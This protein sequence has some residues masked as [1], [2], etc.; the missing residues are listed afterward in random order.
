MNEARKL[1]EQA[2]ELHEQVLES[3]CRILGPDHRDTLFAMEDLARG[4]LRAQ[5]KADE[6]RKLHGE[7]LKIR[8]RILVE[9]PGWSSMVGLVIST[10]SAPD[11][12]NDDRIRALE[13]ARKMTELAPENQMS[14]K[15][16]GGAEYANGHWDAAI[17]ATEKWLAVRGDG[18]WYFSWILL[19][20]SHARR[21]EMDEAHIWYDKARRRAQRGEGLADTPPWIID[22]ATRLFGEHTHAPYPEFQTPPIAG[23]CNNLAWSLATVPDLKLR[24]IPRAIELAQRAVNLKPDAAHSWNTLGVAYYRAGKWKEAIAALEKSQ[25]FKPGGEAFDSIFLAMAHQQLGE[26]DKAR[27][28]YDK[29]VGWIEKNKPLDDELQRFRAEA[30]ELLKVKSGGAD[31]K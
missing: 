4:A 13:L 10:L 26:N 12:S 22:E 5:G 7:T 24:N 6:A 8:R 23:S 31:R 1:H 28:W 9:H 3:R 21:G 17:R 11:P 14:W 18:G 27:A 20:L 16:L 30:A 2:L 29:A 25:S 19:A 15:S